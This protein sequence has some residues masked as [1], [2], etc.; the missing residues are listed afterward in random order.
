MCVN[1]LLCRINTGVCYASSV[2]GV[3]SLACTAA[4][5]CM[6]R[7]LRPVLFVETRSLRKQLTE[8]N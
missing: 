4:W 1:E 2:R 6:S 8:S 7:R 5:D 3:S